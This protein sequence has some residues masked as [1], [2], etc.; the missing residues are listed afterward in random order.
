MIDRIE[1][2]EVD[3]EVAHIMAHRTKKGKEQMTLLESFTIDGI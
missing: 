3:L 2:E 1:E